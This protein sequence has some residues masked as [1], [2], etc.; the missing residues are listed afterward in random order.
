MYRQ[1]LQAW[2]FH[3][4]GAASR[5]LVGEYERKD[6]AP[7]CY[8]D[9]RNDQRP[10]DF[11]FFLE[12]MPSRDVFRRFQRVD[13]RRRTRDKVRETQAILQQPVVILVVDGVRDQARLP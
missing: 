11:D 1:R 12:R 10:I 5:R 2:T 9:E 6:G 3:L 13:S 7:E 8:A 4:R